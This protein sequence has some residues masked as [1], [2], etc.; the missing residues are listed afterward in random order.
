MRLSISLS[1]LELDQLF[2]DDIVT[3]LGGAYSAMH[4]V[5]SDESRLSSSKAAAA[6]VRPAAVVVVVHTSVIV[7]SRLSPAQARSAAAMICIRCAC[8]WALTF[9]VVSASAESAWA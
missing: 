5:I 8:F 2:L 6:G 9:R 1:Q 4:R 7:E 3:E